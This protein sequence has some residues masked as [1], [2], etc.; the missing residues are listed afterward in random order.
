MKKEGGGAK[1]AGTPQSGTPFPG[2]LAANCIQIGGNENKQVEKI[3]FL[4][5]GSPPHPPS[6]SSSVDFFYCFFLS[7]CYFCTAGHYEDLIFKGMQSR[8]VGWCC[9]YTGCLRSRYLFFRSHRFYW[10]IVKY[11]L[12]EVLYYFFFAINIF[13]AILLWFIDRNVECNEN[14]GRDFGMLICNKMEMS[15]IEVL[16]I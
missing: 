11:V 9:A 4:Q 10:R 16:W 13:E 7:V 3:L 14:V 5:N 8:R 15:F 1:S 2:G 6:I 12:S